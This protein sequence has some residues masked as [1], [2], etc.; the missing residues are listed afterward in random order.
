MPGELSSARLGWTLFRSCA[1]S[2]DT[3]I[4]LRLFR[5]SYQPV[6]SEHHCSKLLEVITN[7]EKLA[8][9]LE[10]LQVSTNVTPHHACTMI[11]HNKLAAPIPRSGRAYGTFCRCCGSSKY[12]STTP[13]CLLPL[14]FRTSPPSASYESSGSRGKLSWKGR[15]GSATRM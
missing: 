11:S 9:V 13:T 10:Y 7:T 6:T 3:S 1:Y 4:G 8:E 2:I 15:C 5:Y 12:S 14:S